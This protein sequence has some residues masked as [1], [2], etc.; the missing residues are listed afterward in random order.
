MLEFLL[1]PDHGPSLTFSG[2]YLAMVGTY[3]AGAKLYR[4][5]AGRYVVNHLHDNRSSRIA[6]Y[7]H[8]GELGDAGL[9]DYRCLALAATAG[10]TNSFRDSEPTLD[11]E[12]RDF[13]A[14]PHPA[15]DDHPPVRF[16]GYRV[17]S[18][19]SIVQR[20]ISDRS[21]LYRT[22]GAQCVLATY[23]HEARPGF[24][25]IYPNARALVADVG[26]STGAM[27]LYR[28]A[29]IDTTVSLP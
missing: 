11:F 5:A 7:R 26:Y 15:G 12:A 1:G 13:H 9:N 24:I 10:I 21:D 14:L 2:E 6:T 4:T 17:A 27:S 25:D 20:P 23:V 16:N 19:W 3:T 18:T 29:G 8:A 22:R 28:Q